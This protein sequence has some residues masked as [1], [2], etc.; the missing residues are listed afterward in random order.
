MKKLLSLFL[1]LVFLSGSLMADTDSDEYDGPY[2]DPLPYEKVEFPVWVH[3]IRRCEVIFFG[4]IPLTYI[5]TNLIYDYTIYATHD[6]DS[7]YGI[8]TAR[9]QDDIE[10]MLLTSL[11][12]SG[13]IAVVDLIIDKILY[14]R[15]KKNSKEN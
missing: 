8:G 1:V 7:E 12:I 15:A 14:L 5:F 11:S 4:S 9:D 10:F 6:F 13:G 2:T 3:D